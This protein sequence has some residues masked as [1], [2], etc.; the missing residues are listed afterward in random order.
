MSGHTSETLGPLVI[1]MLSFTCEV[2]FN[3]DNVFA[4]AW[5]C[6]LM[7][8]FSYMSSIHVLNMTDLV[9]PLVPNFVML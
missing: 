9:G 7:F 3:S 1:Q 8:V 4:Y 2:E 6:M 5:K